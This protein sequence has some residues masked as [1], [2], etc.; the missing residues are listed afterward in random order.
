[1]FSK[2][3]TIFFATDRVFAM[4]SYLPQYLFIIL[5][6]LNIIVMG[7]IYSMKMLQFQPKGE[8]KNI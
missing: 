5:T 4:L 2:K 6:L 8:Q 1:M 7:I 3:V